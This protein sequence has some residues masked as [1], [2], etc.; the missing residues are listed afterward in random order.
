VDPSAESQQ[1]AFRCMM[2]GGVD[3]P[4]PVNTIVFHPQHG[5]FATGSCNG[6]VYVWDGAKKKRISSLRRYPTSIASL[7]FSPDGEFLAVASSYTYENGDVAHPADAVFIRRVADTEVRP[8]RPK[9]A[10]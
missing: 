8:K 5:T 4:S 7:A 10:Q 2:V 1:Y 6:H 9:A 3:T